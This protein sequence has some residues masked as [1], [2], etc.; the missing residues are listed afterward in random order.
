M[1]LKRVTMQNI[2]DACGLSRNTVSKIFNGRGAVPDATRRIVLDKAQELGYPMSAQE[3]LPKP[4]PHNQNVAVFTSHI[5]T[6]YH[7]G[8]VFLPAFAGQLGRSGYTLMMYQLTAQEVEQGRLPDNLSLEQT[9]GI[10]GIELF[11]RNYADMLCT[12]GLPTIFVD[13]YPG[14]NTAL[15][16]FDLVSMENIASTIAL[17]EHVISAGAQRIGFVGDINHCNSFRERW[18]GFCAALDGANIPLQRELC[19]LGVDGPQ[20]GDQSW[21]LARL[22]EMPQLPDAL[23]CANDFIAVHLMMAL[24]QMG[25]SIP[26]QIMLTGFDGTPQSAI[27]EPS[28]TTVQI[29]NDD[30]GRITAGLL[31]DRIENPG[32]PYRGTYIKAT[33]IWRESTARRIQRVL[34]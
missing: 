18:M 8:T 13:A 19:I 9:A 10:L 30:I 5:P 33:P 15:L 34:P 6:D 20:Y 26:D 12:L 2:A 21:L 1:I 23:I 32:R 24:K 17:T 4:E 31:L 27:L 22:R 7:F 16:N 29:P 11:D 14:A 3:V 25:V 28:L